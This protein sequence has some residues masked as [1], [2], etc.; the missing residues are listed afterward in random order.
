[1]ELQNRNSSSPVKPTGWCKWTPATAG[2]T[3]QAATNTASGST[4]GQTQQGSTA[5]QYQQGSTAGQTQQVSTSG[6]SGDMPTMPTAAMPAMPT[7][8][9]DTT[10]MQTTTTGA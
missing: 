8:P 1:M 3:L 2:R 7:A 9:M 6:Q 10:A 4:A 5:G